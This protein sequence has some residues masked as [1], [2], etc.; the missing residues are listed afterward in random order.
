[1]IPFTITSKRIKYLGIN[2]GGGGKEETTE[3]KDPGDVILTSQSGLFWSEPMRWL[4]TQSPSVP[5]GRLPKPETIHSFP[6]LPVRAFH[7]VQLL[8]ASFY[9]L[10][11]ILL[12]SLNEP[13]WSLNFTQLNFV[14]NSPHFCCITKLGPIS[15]GPV[16][17]PRLRSQEE[18]VSWGWMARGHHLDTFPEA[19]CFVLCL[20]PHHNRNKPLSISHL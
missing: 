3:A 13:I 14:C 16:V 9:L 19:V 12:N 7:F 8:R 2:L 1:M 11:G 15:Y 5:T 17:Q 4:A 6:L 18:G 20:Y 10:D